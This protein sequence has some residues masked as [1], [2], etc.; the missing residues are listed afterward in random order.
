MSCPGQ[1]GHQPLRVSPGRQILL[2]MQD[3]AVPG[4][5]EPRWEYKIL[6]RYGALL[7]VVVGLLAMGFGAA[8]VCGTA[9]SATLLPLGLISLV[10]GVVLPRIEGKFTAGPTRLSAEILAVHQ[11][12]PPIF[13]ASGPALAVEQPGT[14][15]GELETAAGTAPADGRITIDDVWDA[16]DAAGL[17]PDG[18]GAGSAYF[19]LS[20][21]RAISRCQTGDSPRTDRLRRTSGGARLMGDS[22]CRQRQVQTGCPGPWMDQ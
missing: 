18:V 12:D 7:L 13:I 8:G 20:E 15:A 14:V 19:H 11:L 5:G 4:A 16:L 1:P 22:A 10:A 3:P 17:R 9:I 21:G 2:R 6:W